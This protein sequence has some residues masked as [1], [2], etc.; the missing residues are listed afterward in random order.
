MTKELNEVPPNENLIHRWM[1]YCDR[2]F[3]WIMA[4]LLILLFAGL[5]LSGTAFGFGL[6]FLAGGLFI[7][8]LVPYILIKLFTPGKPEPKADDGREN[9]PK[10]A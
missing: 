10:Q 8:V 1:S 5:F 3:H 7:I 2:I 6:L 4:V 9:N